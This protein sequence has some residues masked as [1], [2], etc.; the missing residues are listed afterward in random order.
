MNHRGLP[1]E[2]RAAVTGPILKNGIKPVHEAFADYMLINPSCTLREMSVY[3]NYSVAWI[4]QVINTD[5]FKAYMS[6]RRAQINTFVA[7]DLPAK[8]AAA[9]HLATE[10]IIEVV[11]KSED[12][13]TLID[14]FDK[15]LHRLGYA[16]NA[17]GTGAAPST[18]INQQ[19]NVFYLQ[20]DE[21]AAAR[22]KLVNAHEEKKPEEPVVHALPA[23]AG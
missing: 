17:K 19:N 18:V 11:E 1:A 22:E 6:E 14:A 8:L 10:R 21:L 9:G 12:A 16:P 20:K 7:A 23:P 2:Q 5:M 15:I 13:P 4:C 3:F